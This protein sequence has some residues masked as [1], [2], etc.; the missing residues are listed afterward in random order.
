M[1]SIKTKISLIMLV[2]LIVP[3]AIITYISYSNS[4]ALEMAVIQKEDLASISAKFDDTFH[5]YEAFLNDISDKP[6][7]DVESYAYPDSNQIET[8]QQLTKLNNYII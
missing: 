7:T 6:E 8:Y 4:A 2:L 5:E 1:K 3:L